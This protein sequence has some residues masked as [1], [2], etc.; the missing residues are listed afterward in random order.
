MKI[1]MQ[2]MFEDVLNRIGDVQNLQIV[3]TSSIKKNLENVVVL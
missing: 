1:G 2:W 3:D